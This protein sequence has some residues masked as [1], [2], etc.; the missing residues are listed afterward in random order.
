[1]KP[2]ISPLKPFLAFCIAVSLFPAFASALYPL[3]G[4]SSPAQDSFDPR[5]QYRIVSDLAG[6]VLDVKGGPTAVGNGVRIQLYEWLG[7]QNQIWFIE[8]QPDGTYVIRSSSSSLVLD[9]QGGP[10]ANSN[11]DRIQ[12][13]QFQG[14]PNQ[15]WRIEPEDPRNSKSSYKIISVQSN[16]VLD[17]EGGTHATQNG[18][19]LQQWDWNDTSNQRWFI[20]PATQADAANLSKDFDY[21]SHNYKGPLSGTIIRKDFFETIDPFDPNTPAVVA[22]YQQILEREPKSEGNYYLEQFQNGEKAKNVVRSLAQSTEYINKFVNGNTSG[23]ALFKQDTI[24]K[25]FIHQTFIHIMTREPTPGEITQELHRF[26]S[27]GGPPFF[28]WESDAKLVVDD[29][30]DSNEYAARFGLNGIPGHP[31]IHI[32]GPGSDFHVDNR[33]AFVIR[34]FDIRKTPAQPNDPRYFIVFEARPPEVRRLLPGH[35][36]VFW[37]T[38]SPDGKSL[39]LTG[40]G[41]YPNDDSN[42][43]FVPSAFTTH[44]AHGQKD[45]PDKPDEDLLGLS[46]NEVFSVE[47]EK[48]DYDATWKTGQSYAGDHPYKLFSQSCIHFDDAIARQL[49]L[50]VPQTLGDLPVSYIKDL[51]ALNLDTHH[52]DQPDGAYTG[53]TLNGLPQGQGTK[54]F[55]NG[56]KYTGNFENGLPS[57][58]GSLDT[59]EGWHVDGSF[60]NG[61]EEGLCHMTGHGYAFRGNFAGGIMDGHITAEYPPMAGR[62]N[63]RVESQYKKG[64]VQ[65]PQDIYF[66]DGK[67]W[68]ALFDA[69]DGHW[70]GTAEYDGPTP[71]RWIAL[72]AS[73]IDPMRKA[74]EAQMGFG[75]TAGMGNGVS[76]APGTTTYTMIPGVNR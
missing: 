19:E 72:P 62:P 48:A 30:I 26:R 29:I 50:A 53:Q 57:G 73:V 51:R 21:F 52:L 66:L 8:S 43:S 25:G 33:T 36:S 34:S 63:A 67:H 6:K 49:G 15:K 24:Q 13:F 3:R 42:S 54:D 37:E 2:L 76:V 16:K 22:L 27:P 7:G 65:S 44:G 68:A 38:Q 17:A 75:I 9:V 4:Q 12:Q 14:T 40:W 46:G 74:I 23:D 11:G 28:P 56:D 39:D 5:I 58:Y 1:M 69:R 10:G 32:Y 61:K 59:P 47:V 71:A 70:I 41:I 20:E 31:D 45:L 64:I 35:A 60:V 18:T 55:K